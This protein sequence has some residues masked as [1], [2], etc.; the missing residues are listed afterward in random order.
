[1]DCDRF[2]QAI[3]TR[4]PAMD[5]VTIAEAERHR[6]ECAKCRERE[7]FLQFLDAAV[8]RIRPVS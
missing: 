5:A 3:D 8:P 4:N 7:K 6:E 1:M 2:L